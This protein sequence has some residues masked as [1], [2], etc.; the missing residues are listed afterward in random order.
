MERIRTSVLAM[1]F[2]LAI[3][4]PLSA[5][6]H[7]ADQATLDQVVA[8][9]VSQKADDREAIRRLLEIEQVREVA[10]GAGLDLK[11][12]E[13]A[14]AALDDAEVGLIAA[15]ARAVNDVLAGGQSTVTI[16]TTVIIVGL[17]VLILLI[18]AI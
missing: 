16:S 12:A 1:L 4:L 14:V 5:H 11:R 2:A 6:Q 3:S 15:Q 7:V 18:V 17:L 9:H 10:K 8:G 13:T